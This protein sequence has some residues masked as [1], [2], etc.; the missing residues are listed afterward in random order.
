MSEKRGFIPVDKTKKDKGD[1][2]SY[3]LGIGIDK[4]QKFD[5]LNNAVSDVTALA[6][7]LKKEYD[8]DETIIIK[9]EKA[10]REHII[11][12]LDKLKKKVSPNDK[13]LIFFSGHGHLDDDEK[14]F[15]IPTDADKS[16][17]AH[18]IRNSTIRDY[19]E[20]FKSLH[21]LLISDSCFSGSLIVRGATRSSSA[22]EDL[23]KKKSRWV[24]CSGGHDQLVYDGSPGKNSPFTSSVIETLK[25]SK[26][27]KINVGKLTELVRELTRAN[28][29]QLPEGYPLFGVGHKGGQ[30]VFCR[31]LFEEEDWKSCQIENTLSAYRSFTK[32]YP[33][34]KFHNEALKQIAEMQ[35]EES[36]EKTR[37]KDKI[38]DYYQFI[39]KYPNSK[40]KEDAVLFIR[41]LEEEKTWKGCL[42]K[43]I[44]S[45]YL[46]YK[47]TFPTGKYVHEAETRIDELLDIEESSEK[48]L[49][50]KK[51]WENAL[52]KKIH[53]L[54]FPPF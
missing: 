3:F 11:D 39:R 9:N 13:L 24:L 36:W 48:L 52:K 19:I 18:Y 26:D 20:D 23:E 47:D 49:E 38:R 37:K 42:K 33:K 46:S 35:A 30:Y 2:K 10:T 28:Y 17:T 6:E 14:G 40:F 22:V 12:Q 45:A 27:A 32:K 1:G 44:I 51:T 29:K 34:S 16:N 50:E 4:Y 43:D 5:S 53:W 15:W 31:K 25:N 7:L 21:T 54:L 41:N 8:I